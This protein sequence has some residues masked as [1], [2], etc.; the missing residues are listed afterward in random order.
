LNGKTEL[1]VEIVTKKN[2]CLLS[3][4]CRKDA[5]KEAKIT[6]RAI[7]RKTGTKKKVTSR[8]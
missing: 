5:R 7:S 3:V 2:A 1:K 8:E 6:Q 4:K